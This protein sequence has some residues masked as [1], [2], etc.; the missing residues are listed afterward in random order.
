MSYPVSKKMCLEK[1]QNNASVPIQANEHDKTKILEQ[2]INQN[3]NTPPELIQNENDNQSNINNVELTSFSLNFLKKF[4][5]S[6]SKMTIK[7]LEELILVKI[8]ENLHYKSDL[9]RLKLKV[10]QQYKTIDK[11]SSRTLDLEKMI[12]DMLLVHTKLEN[13]LKTRCNEQ[14]R[15]VKFTRSVALQAHIPLKEN[16]KNF[17]YKI[18]SGNPLIPTNRTITHLPPN[19]I[20]ISPAN[21]MNKSTVLRTYPGMAKQLSSNLIN[22]NSHPVINVSTG[23]DDIKSKNIVLNGNAQDVVNRVISTNKLRTIFTK[24]VNSPDDSG[25][26]TL[27]GNNF[28]TI[29]SKNPFFNSNSKSMTARPRTIIISRNP[30]AISGSDSTRSIVTNNMT[31]IPKNTVSFN[32]TQNSVNNKI[33]LKFSP[34]LKGDSANPNTENNFQNFK[35]LNSNVTRKDIE[36]ASTSSA[37]ICT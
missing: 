20:K 14:V 30:N 2:N 5:K 12:D 27:N 4:K 34:K 18:Q 35:I 1:Q 36:T 25:M 19:S 15:P 11:M 3:E 26:K 16:Q 24:N 10:E 31:M 28:R 37:S 9:N 8:V 22:V 6:L 21:S 17:K 23:N 29:L 13:D 32:N 33:M 7:D